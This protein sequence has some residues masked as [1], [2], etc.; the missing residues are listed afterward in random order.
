MR[1]WPHSAYRC[2]DK[3][4]ESIEYTFGADRHAYLVPSSGSVEISG[5]RL[6]TPDGAAIRDEDVLRISAIE[7]AELV[8]VDT[9]A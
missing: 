2:D 1:P 8:L 9:A 4:G 5:T 6:A 7:E 3:A